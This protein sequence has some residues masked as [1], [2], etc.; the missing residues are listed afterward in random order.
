MLRGD[1]QQYDQEPEGRHSRRGQDLEAQGGAENRPRCAAVAAAEIFRHVFARG[2]RDAEA[3]DLTAHVRQPTD[4]IEIAEFL[5]TDSPR[6]RYRSRNCEDE[7]KAC[8]QPIPERIVRDGLGI[9]TTFHFGRRPLHVNQPGYSHL[10]HLLGFGQ[11]GGASVRR[12]PSKAQ[13][14]T[15]PTSSYLGLSTTVPNY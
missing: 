15:K 1:Q 5:R 6:H 13:S 12:M 9:S 3:A 14:T 11:R 10:F 8:F 7:I 2:G 4:V